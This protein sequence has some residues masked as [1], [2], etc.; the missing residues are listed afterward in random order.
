LKKLPGKLHRFEAV[1]EGDFPENMYPCARVMPLKERA[2][3]MFIKNDVEDGRYY[4]GKLAVVKRISE[5]NITVTFNDNKQDFVLRKET[6]E[7]I[8]YS[9]EDGSDKIQKD[10]L[11]TFS[12]YPL[13]L[14]W[15]VT[16]HKSQGLTFDKVIIDA[17]QS[18]AAGQAYVALSRCRSLEG[19]VLHSLIHQGVLHGDERITAF[20]DSHHHAGALQN[21]LAVAKAEY[22]CGLLLQLFTFEKLKDRVSE[23]KEL[24]LDKNIPEKETALAC[25]D[26]IITGTEAIIATS[27]KFQPELARM[28]EAYSTNT[29]NT[30]LIKERCEKA[31]NYFTE[32]IFTLLITQLHEHITDFAFKSRVKT[33]MRHLQGLE[34]TFWNKMTRLYNAHF[35]DERLYRGE[36][37]H[38]KDSLKKVVTSVTSGKKEKGGT[39]RDTLELH[40]QGKKIEEIALTRSLAP[41]TIKGHLAKWIL[42]GEI[43]VREVLPVETIQ[44]IEK[45][46]QSEEFNTYS[47]MKNTFG[48]EVDYGDIRMVVNHLAWKRGMEVLRS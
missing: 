36:I 48:N 18:F 46:L 1:I 33:Y 26:K 43:A 23:W 32:N 14:A 19:I 16:I 41:S 20:S 21:E 10:Q 35:L 13:R 25:L 39:Y 3:V 34:D 40:R 47:D 11:G 24:L 5:H 27:K 44:R 42:A 31:I 28:L 45:Y 7:N 4:N 30:A 15:A 8:R 12:Q 38:K 17:G 22:A 9:M 37:K 29:N 6:W 2:Q